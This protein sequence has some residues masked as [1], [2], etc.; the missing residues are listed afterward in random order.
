MIYIG[1][2]FA[3]P[4]LKVSIR[5]DEIF[6]N[7]KLNRYFP[8][9]F[10]SLWYVYLASSGPTLALKSQTTVYEQEWSQQPF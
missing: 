10:V 9:L 5:N 2:Q 4:L 6:L 1:P 3:L 8:F 7:C